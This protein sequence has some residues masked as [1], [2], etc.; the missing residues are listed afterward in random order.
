MDVNKDKD[1]QM[2]HLLM[3]VKNT[4]QLFHTHFRVWVVLIVEDPT[5]TA[6]CA[7]NILTN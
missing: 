5:V 7:K 6:V 2:Y 4:P 1:T 3:E